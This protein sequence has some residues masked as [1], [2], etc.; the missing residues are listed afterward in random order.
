M[1]TVI[2]IEIKGNLIP[3]DSNP[4][5]LYGLPKN[6][7]ENILFTAIINL[8]GSP[9]CTFATYLTNPARKYTGKT[10]SHILNSSH[11]VSLLSNNT[12]DPGNLLISFEVTYLLPKVPIQDSI[13]IIQDL[14]LH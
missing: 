7:K 13:A 5:R 11:L 14:L 1:S 8:I 3:Q 4:P 10:S 12:L 6:H 9:T 2:S